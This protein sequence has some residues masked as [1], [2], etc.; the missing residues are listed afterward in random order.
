VYVTDLDRLDVDPA[1]ARHLAQVLRLRPGEPVVAS[2][3]GGLWR[4]CRIAGDAHRHASLTLALE[5]DGPVLATAPPSHAVTVGFVPA[6]GQRPEWV[7]QKLTEAGVDHIVVL[8][9]ARAVVHWE[10]ERAVR[11][12]DRL[13]RVAREAA[14]QSRR[15][16]L[17][18]VTGV[19]GLDDLAGA[20]APSPLAR[21]HPGA[22]PPDRQAPAVA[23]GPEGGWDPAEIANAPLMGLGH[24]IL[25]AETAAVAAGLLLCWLR[26]GVVR[27]AA[28]GGAHEVSDAVHA[29]GSCNHHAE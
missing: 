13:R 27:P 23:V 18:K 14:A 19:L 1:D 20:L 16:W 26:D 9:S 12:V 25:R 29:E 3:G 17:P 28:G 24:H 6:K 10:D 21:A 15:A 2:D 5:A 7:V 11:V 22:P 4:L 8:R